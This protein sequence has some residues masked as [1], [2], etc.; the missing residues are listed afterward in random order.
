MLRQQC[1]RLHGTYE[2]FPSLFKFGN[3]AEASFLVGS[4]KQSNKLSISAIVNKIL[5]HLYQKA[6]LCPS[7]NNLQI[8]TDNI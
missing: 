2:M 4:S 7:A 1:L 6:S 5:H 8:D 3:W